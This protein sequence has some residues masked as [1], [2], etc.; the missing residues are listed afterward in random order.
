MA[1][2]VEHHVHESPKVMTI[3]LMILAFFSLTIGFIGMPIIP[4][5]NLFAEFLA[6]VF[7]A[8]EHGGVDHTLEIGLMAFSVLVA[9]AG[10]RLAKVM[11]VNNTTLPDLIA[12]KFKDSYNL[13]LNKYKVDEFYNAVFVDGLVHRLAKV[14][15]SVADVKIVDGAVNGIARVIG[16][17]SDRSRK[18]QTGLVQEYA[19]SMGLG[20]VLLVGLYY[21]L[22]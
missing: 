16:R 13:L 19:F 3:P 11:Y 10:W 18:V 9:V 5:G 4:H 17:T 2:E 14:L 12:E 15:H 22:K 21:I 6:P 20:L 8:A 1:P 7:P